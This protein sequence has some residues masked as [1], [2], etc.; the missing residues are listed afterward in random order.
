MPLNPKNWF[1]CHMCDQVAYM[2]DCCKTASCGGE[3][4]EQCLWDRIVV[5]RLIESGQAPRA[6]DLEGLPISLN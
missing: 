4:C 5:Q 6:E 3:G 1:F 2:F